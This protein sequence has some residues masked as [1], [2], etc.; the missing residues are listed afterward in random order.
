MS[1][2][3]NGG[4]LMVPQLLSEV[5][6]DEG[7]IV[8]TIRPQLVRSVLSKQAVEVVRDALVNVVSKEGTARLAAVKGFKVAGKTGT[9]Q[10]YNTDG[11]VSR[12]RHRVAFVGFMP[13]QAPE[14]SG[15][16]MLEQ[17]ETAHGQD[18]GGLVAAPIFSRIG[19]RAARYLG[20]QPEPEPTEA[21]LS[22]NNQRSRVR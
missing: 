3:A 18:M 9:A 7:H 6:D 20:L 14:F 5:F 17:P 2:I 15:I 12:D 21:G 10:V 22:Q 4:N 16:V 11:T 8:E 13:A 1:V 19:E